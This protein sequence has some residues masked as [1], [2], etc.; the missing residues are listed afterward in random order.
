M[1]IKKSL[2]SGGELD[3]ALHDN[4]DLQAWRI[5]LA[6]ALNVH[7]GKNGRVLNDAGSYF[8]KAYDSEVRVCPVDGE[9]YVLIFYH[10]GTEGRVQAVSLDDYMSYSAISSVKTFFNSGVD[11]GYTELTIP[12]LKFKT[13]R[14][15][16]GKKWLYVV[17][18]LGHID[19]SVGFNSIKRFRFDGLF[20]QMK[21]VT[22]EG[23]VPDIEGVTTTVQT[24]VDLVALT[25]NS[26]DGDSVYVL[27]DASPLLRGWYV[28]NSLR[29]PQGGGHPWY[30]I[31]TNSIVDLTAGSYTD[32]KVNWD[33]FTG[34]TVQYG[35]TL[36]TDKGEESPIVVINTYRPLGSTNTAEYTAHSKL[37]STATT[38]SSLAYNFNNIYYLHSDFSGQVTH[39]RVYRRPITIGGTF[40]QSQVAGAFGY[41]GDGLLSVNTPSNSTVVAGSNFTNNTF[42]VSYTEFN[43]QADFLNQPAYVSQDLREFMITPTSSERNHEMKAWGIGKYGARNVYWYKD[44]LLFSRVGSPNNFLRNF[45]TDEVNSFL[46]QVGLG[47]TT[48]SSVA[49]NNGLIIFTDKGVY[50]GVNEF[51]SQAD[52][53]IKRAGDWVIDSRVEPLVTPFGVLFIDSTSN[54]IRR[55]GFSQE[56]Q[57]F[58][59]Q[60]VAALSSHLFYN[61]A[62]V[63]W[64]FRGGDSPKII[65]ILDD[66]SAV[67]MC[68]EERNKVFGF[69]PKSCYADY[70][71]VITYKTNN[72]ELSI[73]VIEDNGTKN[74]E[75]ES[76]RRPKNIASFDIFETV[77][78][79]HSTVVHKQTGATFFGELKRNNVEDWGS[80]L[81]IEGA[82]LNL[83]AIG[84]YFKCFNFETNESC[85]LKLTSV[86][87]NGEPIFT[88]AENPLPESMQ[89]VDVVLFKATKLVTGL[90]HLE[91]EFVSIIADNAVVSS[92]YNPNNYPVLQVIDGQITLKDYACFILV[93]RPYISDFKTLQI[94]TDGN[95]TTL[96]KPKLVGAAVVKYDNSRGGYVG[97]D[98]PA[99]NSV[100]D[101]QDA[102]CWDSNSLINKPILPQTVR[103]TYRLMSN[104][105]QNGSIAFRQVDP[106]PIEVMS[107]IL[108]VTGG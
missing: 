75:I 31:T 21:D 4:V 13:I 47:D 85:L 98:L 27:A 11:S 15:N 45:P 62:V 16:D 92:P 102:E 14:H 68:Y 73:Y 60:D 19:D 84:D 83:A 9:G 26:Y 7:A 38:L 86:N 56:Q 63:S 106:L 64:S 28:Y 107:V 108:N 88:V 3:P 69:F 22:I 8:L 95:N 101:M 87:G 30:R 32:T 91:E 24:V 46:L 89:A 52:P 33:A 49:E 20:I 71:S 65:I 42:S 18:S 99:D 5:A 12:G 77:N 34:A 76:Q 82:A 70:E 2:F 43:V 90:E 97:G 35:L 50:V 96:L 61:K 29:N 1:D 94:D 53:R 36:V 6:K 44:K 72:R 37:P 103:K 41:V 40:G 74:I 66:G 54:T 48:I 104:W 23:D 55:L 79:S 78:F 17:D 10:N 67:S 81:V 93:G 57:E 58:I 105:G 25:P 59:G 100:T 80:E 51:V 39:A